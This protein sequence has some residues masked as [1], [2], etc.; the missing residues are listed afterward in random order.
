MKVGFLSKNFQFPTW[1][2]QINTSEYFSKH[3]EKK[4]IFQKYP[5]KKVFNLLRNS[6]KHEKIE[7][8]FSSFRASVFLLS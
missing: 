3:W 7:L 2:K 5:Q 1:K 6:I 4:L 8:F